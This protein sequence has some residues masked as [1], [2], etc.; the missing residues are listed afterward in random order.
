M[1]PQ[2]HNM[3]AEEPQHPQ[4]YDVDVVGPQQNARLNQPRSRLSNELF[5][6]F[7]TIR[8]EIIDNSLHRPYKRMILRCNYCHRE[9]IYSNTHG[10]LGLRRHVS[11]CL[12]RH[13][14]RDRINLARFPY[15]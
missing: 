8:E 7:T 10:T 4:E 15:P 3:N 2:Q 1:N 5:Q 9:V 13:L 6:N 11:N 12:A 14:S